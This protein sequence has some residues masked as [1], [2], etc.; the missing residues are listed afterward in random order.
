MS[1]GLS[2]VTFI[3]ADPDR[4]RDVLEQVLDARCVYDSG[5]ETFSVS[6]ERFFMVGDVWV[7][8]MRGPPLPAR[9]YNHVA[10]RIGEGEYDAKLAR[11]EALGLEL[12]PPR[13]RVDG[14][15]RSIYFYGPDNHLFELHTGT[16]AQR[17]AR[18]AQGRGPQR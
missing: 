5:L 10:F 3:S 6:E 13:P 16:L 11:I 2:H 18:Y 8:V 7:A 9:S 12:R 17:L 1:S 15:G 14:E 4:M